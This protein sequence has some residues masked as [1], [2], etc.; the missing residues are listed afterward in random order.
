MAFVGAATNV[1]AYE[2]LS[3]FDVTTVTYNTKPQVDTT[4]ID[5]YTGEINSQVELIHFNIT[6]ILYDWISGVKTNNGIAILGYDNTLPGIGAFLEPALFI[7]YVETS[8]Y[9]DHFDHHTQDVGRAGTSYINDFTQ[10]LTLIR[11]DLAI[12]GNIMPV[13]I[14]FVYNSAFTTMVDKFSELYELEDG[15]VRNIPQV[16]GNNWI[17][18]YNRGIFI[19]EYASQFA[20]TLSYFTETGTIINFVEEEQ[21]DG[22]KVYVE[23]KSDVFG[24]SGETVEAL[25]FEANANAPVELCICGENCDFGD[26]CPCDC[27]SE[28]LCDC[29]ECK[30]CTCSDCTNLE[31]TCTC[32]NEEECTCDSCIKMFDIQYDEHG[33]LRSIKIA[34]KML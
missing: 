14:S 33:N 1:A 31:C 4:V 32:S 22:S 5:Y 10:K 25:N 8:G 16:Y 6:D 27:T 34:G 19:N 21:E 11:D 23:E 30:G 18:N 29:A 15:R 26:G 12:S 7:E 3:D 17:T 2:I 20:P 9:D 13:S 28:T 24:D